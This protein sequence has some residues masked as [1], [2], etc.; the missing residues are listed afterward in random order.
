MAYILSL[1]KKTPEFA[2]LL[3]VT[4]R[5]YA[6]SGDLATAMA[7]RRDLSGKL[8]SVAIVLYN[9]RDYVLAEQYIDKILENDPRNWRMRLYRARIRIRQ[10]RWGEADIVLSEMLEERPSDVGVLHAMG[11]SLS[12]QSKPAEALKIFAGIIAR[13][14][15]GASLR[16]AADCLHR[17]R[18]DREALQFLARAKEREPE[19]PFVLDLESRILE[20]LG[21]LEPAYESALLASAAIRLMPV[22]RIAWASFEPNNKNPNL[23]YL[24]LYEPLNSMLTFL[25]PPTPWPPPIL[26]RGEPGTQKRCCRASKGRP[27]LHRT[28]RSSNIRVRVWRYTKVSSSKPRKYFAEK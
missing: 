24:T 16:D 5:L 17:M 1:D 9:R 22:Y 27:E 2:L 25:A 28:K 11:W 20:D 18:R 19:N 23:Q 6:L 7:L 14:E 4:Y 15:H 21:E 3:P 12:K 10:E 26:M 8:E 13:R